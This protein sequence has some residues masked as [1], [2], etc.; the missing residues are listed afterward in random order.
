[1]LSSDKRSTGTRR[2]IAGGVKQMIRKSLQ[3]FTDRVT[4]AGCITDEDVEILRNDILRDGLATRPEAEA[5]LVLDRTLQTA[6]NWQPVLTR[7]VV[8][9]AVWRLPPAGIAGNDVALW[10]ATVLD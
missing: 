3:D 4:G 10:L 9:F 1:M 8:D 5:L 2:T 7:L 6:G